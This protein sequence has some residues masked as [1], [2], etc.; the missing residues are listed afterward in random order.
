MQLKF[1]NWDV[2]LQK[3][4][5]KSFMVTCYNWLFKLCRVKAFIL[6]IHFQQEITQLPFNILPTKWPKG[7]TPIKGKTLIRAWELNQL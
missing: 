1:K 3:E 6:K 5:L 2:L 4:L 7:W